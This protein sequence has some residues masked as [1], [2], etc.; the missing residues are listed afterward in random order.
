MEGLIDVPFHVV[1]RRGIADVVLSWK[2]K[3]DVV[4][5]RETR[6]EIETRRHLYVIGRRLERID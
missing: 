6:L 2:E 1:M 3:V 4:K 5:I